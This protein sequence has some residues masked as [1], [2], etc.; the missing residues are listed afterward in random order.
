MSRL[1]ELGS[2]DRVE[3]LAARHARVARLGGGAMT[4]RELCRLGL[5][6]QGATAS[7]DGRLGAGKGVQAVKAGATRWSEPGIA[8]L[9]DAGLS[10]QLDRAFVALGLPAGER[11][12]DATLLFF[13]GV[14]LGSVQDALLIQVEEGPSS[15]SRVVE[16]EVASASASLPFRDNLRALARGAP[17]RLR[18][19]GRV[20]PERSLR[21]ELLAVGNANETGG[22]TLPA[23]WGGRC[24]LGLDRLE[25]AFLPST[26]DGGEAG[27]P[28][29]AVETPDALLAVRRWIERLAQGGRATIFPGA[30]QKI[31]QDSRSLEANLMPSAAALLRGL[32]RAA[33]DRR[34]GD[35]SRLAAAFLAASEYCRVAQLSLRRLSW[36][37]EASGGS[38][39]AGGQ[40]Q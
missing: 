33:L 30:I 2:V 18:C 11:K 23:E 12:S 7:W 13:T 32:A 19:I 27:A 10:P 3:P 31:E 20:V 22:L 39:E 40:A 24:N 8:A 38:R 5:F 25:G 21:V 28:R 16:A 14:V 15:M 37:G 17:L 36:G 35:A 29:A 9:F 26:G 34:P 6:M 4:H 1:V